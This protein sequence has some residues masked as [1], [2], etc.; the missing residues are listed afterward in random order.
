MTADLRSDVLKLRLPD[1]TALPT[2]RATFPVGGVGG[3]FNFYEKKPF[4]KFT[5]KKREYLGF[6]HELTEVVIPRYPNQEEFLVRE[7]S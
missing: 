2:Q 1:I 6:R 7:I 4:P 3:A 5:G